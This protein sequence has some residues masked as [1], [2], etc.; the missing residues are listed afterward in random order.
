MSDYTA[1]LLK[2]WLVPGQSEQRIVL[3]NI[4]TGEELI[5]KSAELL[6]EQLFSMPD[7]NFA[8]LRAAP[9]TGSVQYN[10]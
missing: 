4:H 8:P 2:V 9:T 1:Y 3:K 10:R 6:V 7:D 5:L